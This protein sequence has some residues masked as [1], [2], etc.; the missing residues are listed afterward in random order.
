MN[1]SLN[2]GSAF[3]QVF[4]GGWGSPGQDGQEV[5]GVPGL[6]GLNR[7][8]LAAANQ[9]H[10]CLLAPLTH[11][12]TTAPQIPSHRRSRLNQPPP[13]PPR[14]GERPDQTESQ[15]RNLPSTSGASTTRTHPPLESKRWNHEVSL[16]RHGF[17]AGLCRR[18]GHHRA[19][20]PRC[21]PR[22]CLLRAP[23]C[24][25]ALDSRQV[26]SPNV[27]GGHARKSRYR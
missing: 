16:R 21:R 27:S 3:G 20:S 5:L 25:P 18:C 10:L 23:P 15:T 4:R 19:E 11:R 2:E 13:A 6:A 7:P 22:T 14:P 9:L 24:P 1:D 26:T 17:A 12:S 8:T